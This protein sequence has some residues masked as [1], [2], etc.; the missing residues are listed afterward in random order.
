MKCSW[1]SG[2][3]IPEYNEIAQC[4]GSHCLMCGRS[5]NFAYE[6]KVIVIQ[7]ITPRNDKEYG[8]ANSKYYGKQRRRARGHTFREEGRY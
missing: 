4:I 8:A 1:C 3:I 2:A 5:T 7:K 6:V